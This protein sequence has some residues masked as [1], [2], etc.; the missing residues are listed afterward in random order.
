MIE[1]ADCG[2]NLAEDCPHDA[3]LK[4]RRSFDSK[5]RL[6]VLASFLTLLLT[7]IGYL[8]WHGKWETHVDESILSLEKTDSR[9]EKSMSEKSDK[10]DKRLERIEDKLD[11]VLERRGH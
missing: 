4:D 11:K 7:G 8:V 6:D 10:T 9:N 2:N 3:E 5:L 1:K